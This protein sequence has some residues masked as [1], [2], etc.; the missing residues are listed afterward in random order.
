MPYLH[1]KKRVMI[2]YR[3]YTLR[4]FY[5]ICENSYR[6][7]FSMHGRRWDTPITNH[8]KSFHHSHTILE[9]KHGRSGYSLVHRTEDFTITC[10]SSTCVTRHA[11]PRW[12]TN[13]GR[14][15]AQKND[16]FGQTRENNSNLYIVVKTHSFKF[17]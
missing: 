5:G 3:L 6:V 7:R 11:C 17:Q 13:R 9:K 15:P 1:R 4:K 2:M 16:F 14:R 12:S 8:T 10:S